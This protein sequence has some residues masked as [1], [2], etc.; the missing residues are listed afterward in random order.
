MKTLLTLSAT[1]CAISLLSSS[2]IASEYQINNTAN[3]LASES[4]LTTI[5]PMAPIINAKE[6]GGCI[7]DQEANIPE[8]LEND[9]ED[10]K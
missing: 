8:N 4:E 9:I 2:A 5:V 7:S 10:L 3:S 1:L 6:V